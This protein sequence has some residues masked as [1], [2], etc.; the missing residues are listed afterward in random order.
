MDPSPLY[1]IEWQQTGVVWIPFM[2]GER[3][4]A[5]EPEQ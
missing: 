1:G 3:S 5:V 2:N 4:K